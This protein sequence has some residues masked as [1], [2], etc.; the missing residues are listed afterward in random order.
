MPTTLPFNI[1]KTVAKDC[2]LPEVKAMSLADQDHKQMS[3][4]RSTMK[5]IALSN[6]VQDELTE[7]L[8]T[9]DESPIKLHID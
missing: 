2:F 7:D 1:D 6:I 4:K 5:Q 9:Q 3:E 8:L